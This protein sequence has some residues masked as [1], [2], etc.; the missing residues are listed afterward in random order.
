MKLNDFYCNALCD[1]GASISVMHKSFYDMLDLKPLEECHLYVHLADSSKKKPLGRV[2][3]VIIVVN[4]N[5]VPV[6]FIVM[7]IECNASCPIILGRLF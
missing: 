1:L 5:Y 2:D 6:D 7:D 4:N 3:D